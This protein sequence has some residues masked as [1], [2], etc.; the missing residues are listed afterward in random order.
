[1][2]LL[3]GFTPSTEFVDL[4]VGDKTGNV[5][6]FE[7][8]IQTSLCFSIMFENKTIAKENLDE[9]LLLLNLTLGWFFAINRICGFESG[10]AKLEMYAG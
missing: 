10:G 3:G 1:M 5:R 9:T 2:R 4:K 7:N 8:K 6:R